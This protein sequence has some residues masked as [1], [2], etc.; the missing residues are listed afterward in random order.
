MAK[1]LIVDD[2][3]INLE[4][5]SS[6]LEVCGHEVSEAVNGSDALN[7]LSRQTPDL[8]ITDLMMPVMDGL[9]LA[10]CLRADAATASIP[11]IFYTATYRV[12]E[13]RE[14]ASSCGVEVVLPKP[15]EPQ[16]ILDAIAQVLKLDS[17]TS[18]RFGTG[19]GNPARPGRIEGLQQL[20]RAAVDAPERGISAGGQARFRADPQ[21]VAVHSLSLRLAAMLELNL[22]LAAER[23]SQCM[24]DQFCQ[25]AQQVLGARIVVA[26]VGRNWLLEGRELAAYGL[27]EKQLIDL[28]RIPMDRGFLAESARGNE[29]R[30]R[31]FQVQPGDTGLPD[32][33]PP[34]EHLLVLP[35]PPAE[36]ICGLVYFADK[37]ER[38]PFNDEDIQFASSLTTQLALA[39]GNLS[40]LEDVRQHA[41][42]LRVEANERS[43]VTAALTESEA[44]FRQ[45]AENISS[46][47]FLVDLVTDR[48]L[49][50]SPSYEVIWG[51]SCASLYADPQSWI[52]AVHPLDRARVAASDERQRRESGFE[53]EYR[54]VHRDG[55]V[56]WVWVR[57]FPIR[58]DTGRVTRLAAIAEDITER[59]AAQE[60]IADSEAR[61]RQLFDSN[62]LPLWVYDRETLAFLAVN[63]AAIEHYGYSRAEFLAMSIRELRPREDLARLEVAVQQESD[64]IRHSGVWRHRRRDDTLIDV[65]ITSHSIN[66]MGREAR[67]VLAN[68]VSERV[69]Q[70][71]RIARLTR[72]RELIGGI[73][74]A[75]L[76]IR[77]R[78]S[79]LTEACRVA[80]TAGVFPLC[81]IGVPNVRDQS[82]DIVASYGETPGTIDL[83]ESLLRETQF[84]DMPST[85]AVESGQPV[86]VNNFATEPNLR[87]IYSRLHALGYGSGAAFPLMVSGGASAALVLLAVEPGAFDAEE[88]SL[89]AW[90]AAD[91]SFALESIENSARLDHLAYYD[92]LTGLANSRL[93]QDR[94]TQFT[95]AAIGEGDKLAVVIIDLEGFTQINE[96]FGREVGDQLL[97]GVAERLGEQLIEPYALSRIGSDTFVIASPREPEVVATRL[98]E[99]VLNALNEPFHC[100][101]QLIRIGAQAGIAIFPDDAADGVE[102]FRNAETALSLAKATGE[103]YL[104]YSADLNARVAERR[105]LLDDLQAALVAEQFEVHYQSR[106]DMISGELVGA[107][108]LIRWQH[109][110]RGL[111][112]SAEFIAIAEESGLIVPLGTWVLRTVCA[113]QARWISSGLRCVPIAVNL[114]S[115]Q[116]EQDNLLQ[117]IRDALEMHSLAARWLDFELTE[118]AVMKDPEAAAR[119]LTALR[120]LGV[121]L[122]LD[123]FGTGYSSLAYLKRFPFD[124][125]KIDRS[126]VTDI[127]RNPEDAAIATAII[128][129]AHTLKLKVVA[130]GVENEGQFNFLRQRSCDEMQGHYFGAAVNSLAFEAQLQTCRRLQIPVAPAADQDTLLLVD[131]EP[132]IR[133]SLMRMLRPDGYRVL[134]AT[135]GQEGLDLLALNRVHVIISDQRMPGMSGTEFLSRV[136]EMYPDTVRMILSGYTDLAVVTDA[137]NRG[138]VYK[139]LTKPWDDVVLRKQVRDAFRRY[140][141]GKS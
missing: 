8:I 19:P 84:A 51:K 27:G 115:I 26:L 97:R 59:H 50:V 42:Q 30:Q 136:K 98:R 9:E 113:Q 93:F 81:W 132:G 13:A 39:Y 60:A 99:S 15:S 45:L 22:T 128:A 80:G 135:S 124:S 46:V 6:L 65:E 112:S 5:L 103:R 10:R 72:I 49:Y 83:V 89:L 123:D 57:G 25:A 16:V 67:L 66:F 122:A 85:R 54:V 24:L 76:R 1:I 75:M 127:T 140:Q 63:A 44:R 53:H 33:H 64:G 3:A 56:R 130:E 114:S 102:L 7:V 141:R 107:E 11:V 73:N 35:M 77:D 137:V 14:L 92:A 105:Q 88:I 101:G 131:D 108:A 96:S 4:F 2:R 109:P 62:P 139:F 31:D 21:I 47:F 106:I 74:S 95:L 20:L 55:S 118:S 104:Y 91:L 41:G 71:Q 70:A 58:N 121:G 87:P 125:V 90:L 86:V 43:R 61:Y 110:R 111:V 82:L 52:E 126:F 17:A 134:V 18:S 100:G 79:L 29:P 78:A 138:S 117:I 12:H 68:D 119:T 34:V 94:L 116:F 28:A 129:M 23:N 48:T 38:A 120:G 36:G 32:S 133:S 37:R 69:R 40:M